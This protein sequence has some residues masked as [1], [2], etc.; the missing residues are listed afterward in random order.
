MT[1]PLISKRWPET[2]ILNPAF[3]WDRNT[4]LKAR[5]ERE[6]QKQAAGESNVKPITRRN[7]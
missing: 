7:P 2:H 4:D 6:R 1:K 3:K 5:F